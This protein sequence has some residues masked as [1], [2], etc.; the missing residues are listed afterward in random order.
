[1]TLKKIGL[2]TIMLLIGGIIT[3]YF[4]IVKSREDNKKKFIE[5][6]LEENQN[7]FSKPNLSNKKISIL[8]DDT[9]I[10]QL[11]QLRVTLINLADKDFKDLK[12]YFDIY[13]LLGDSIKLVNVS[14]ARENN[15]TDGI[16]LIDVLNPSNSKGG[17]KKG[18]S[19]SSLNRKEDLTASFI[20]DFYF[21]GNII[22]ECKVFIDQ[23]D[24]KDQ[25]GVEA[26]LFDFNNINLIPWYDAEWVII[27]AVI[28]FYILVIVILVRI[29]EIG[30]EKRRSKKENY[31]ITKLKQNETISILNNSEDIAKEILY[32]YDLYQWENTSKIMKLILKMKE[33]IRH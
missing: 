24:I 12:I 22:P 1:M 2:N 14:A 23:P 8:L 15:I 31:I 9:P 20:V 19:L 26:R 29:S 3:Y 25:P 28:L 13:N 5:Y 10:E 16:Q 33:P 27:S 21:E 32:L 18:Y 7:V 30:A 4:T 17:I 11:S 6:K